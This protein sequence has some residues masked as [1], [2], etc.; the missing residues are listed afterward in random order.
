MK[1]AN[2]KEQKVSSS[3]AVEL[4]EK[5]L[6]GLG[7]AFGRHDARTHVAGDSVTKSKMPSECLSPMVS[8]LISED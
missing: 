2:L 6:H 4:D 7:A 5:C 3:I 8:Y 1:S